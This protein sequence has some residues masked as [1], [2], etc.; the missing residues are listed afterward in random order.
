MGG[1]NVFLNIC[2]L[3]DRSQTAARGP[4]KC[5]VQVLVLALLDKDTI[6]DCP[7]RLA[8]HSA[9]NI[10]VSRIIVEYTIFWESVGSLHCTLFD[11]APNLSLLMQTGDHPKRKGTIF[12]CSCSHL[13]TWSS[14]LH[15]INYVHVDLIGLKFLP[16]RCEHADPREVRKAG[17][18]HLRRYFSR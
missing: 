1:L 7:S 12:K 11:T 9:F 2:L 13:Y 4:S 16:C 14:R 10:F 15:Q 5:V 3:A 6:L 18:S 17:A 8:F